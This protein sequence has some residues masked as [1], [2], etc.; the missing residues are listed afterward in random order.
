[1]NNFLGG[2]FYCKQYVIALL[3]SGM[4]FPYM[5]E[6]Q[7]WTLLNPPTPYTCNLFTPVSS[8]YGPGLSATPFFLQ[9]LNSFQNP[10]HFDY[11]L[12][13]FYLILLIL[14]YAFLYGKVLLLLLLLFC[15]AVLISFIFSSCTCSRTWYSALFLFIV[16]FRISIYRYYALLNFNFLYWTFLNLTYPKELHY[17]LPYSGVCRSAD[18]TIYLALAPDL[19]KQPTACVI[20]NWKYLESILKIHCTGCPCTGLLQFSLIFN[21]LHLPQVAFLQLTDDG[22]NAWII[23]V[24][25]KRNISVR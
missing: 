17:K 9:P 5:I 19:L 6:I 13:Y 21:R 2:I 3:F 20:K 10:T 7:R 12:L 25:W 22:W 15:F 8:K 1:M 23:Y 18:P 11:L 4:L 14:P 24:L 16:G